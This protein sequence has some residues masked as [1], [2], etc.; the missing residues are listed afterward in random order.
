M[1]GSHRLGP[2]RQVF[3][4][5]KTKVVFEFAN[6]FL[7]LVHVEPCLSNAVHDA[8]SVLD[9][10]NE[11]NALKREGGSFVT[12]LGNIF[13]VAVDGVHKEVGIVNCCLAGRLNFP[14][15]RHVLGT[16]E[17]AKCG[18]LERVLVVD[19]VLCTS[20]QREGVQL[21]RLSPKFLLDPRGLV[22]A[23]QNFVCRVDPSI[24]GSAGRAVVPSHGDWLPAVA[25]RPCACDVA[26]VAV[27]MAQG[28]HRGLIFFNCRALVLLAQ[29]VNLVPRSSLVLRV[30]PEL[31]M[32]AGTIV[33]PNGLDADQAV[34]C[35]IRCFLG[36]PFT[37]DS[38]FLQWAQVTDQACRTDPA[39]SFK[40][41]MTCATCLAP[42]LTLRAVAHLQFTE[43]R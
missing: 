35:L 9:A 24:V 27:S 29:I 26:H 34:E 22:N 40:Q 36:V 1:W 10:K 25:C 18:F 39:S 43:D 31:G 21:A 37:D 2:L 23:K 38:L 4:N 19:D 42:A 16:F 14:H 32:A 12:F 17:L 7:L 13:D 5:C 6:E 20:V 33:P 28:H 41:H 3:G 30:E 15:R 8:G 11:F